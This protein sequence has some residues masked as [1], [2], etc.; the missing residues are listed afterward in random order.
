MDFNTTLNKLDEILTPQEQKYLA[1]NPAK[2]TELIAKK[3]NI[4]NPK[5][6]DNWDV[7]L[8]TGKIIRKI[9]PSASNKLDVSL[10][11]KLK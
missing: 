11:N 2:K 6:V 1:M 8:K 7:D 9:N 3:K 4:K 10:S 5:D